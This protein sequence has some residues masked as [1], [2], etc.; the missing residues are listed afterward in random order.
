MASLEG[1]FSVVKLGMR[2]EVGKDVELLTQFFWWSALPFSDPARY[3][4][5]NSST[6][7]E[8]S[9]DPLKRC[10]RIQL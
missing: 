9:Y 1:F 6:S 5:L 4:F 3:Q 10:N 7:L 2:E 8:H